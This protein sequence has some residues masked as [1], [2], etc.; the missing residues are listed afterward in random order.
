MSATK[1]MADGVLQA[2]KQTAVLLRMAEADACAV[3]VKSLG[4]AAYPSWADRHQLR[5][6]HVVLARL[7]LQGLGSEFHQRQRYQYKSKLRPTRRSHNTTVQDGI[8]KVANESD[9][10]KPQGEGS[11]TPAERDRV[12]AALQAYMKQH[13]ISAYDLAVRINA[14]GKKIDPKTLHR[15]LDRR[16]LVDDS[17]MEVY[18]VFVDRPG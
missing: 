9:W 18:R 12:K 11:M 17:I 1:A 4:R 16:L 6:L 2:R 3:G 8:Q 7:Y 10:R 5:Y 15:F 13:A 14:E